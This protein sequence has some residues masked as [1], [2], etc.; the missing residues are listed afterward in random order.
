MAIYCIYIVLQII[1]LIKITIETKMNVYWF[2]SVI[3]VH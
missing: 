1:I 3:D 2:T